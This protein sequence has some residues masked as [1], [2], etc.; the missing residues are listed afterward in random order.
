MSRNLTAVC[1]LLAGVLLAAGPSDATSIVG[2]ADNIAYIPV[3][4]MGYT[5]KGVTVGIIDSGFPRSTHRT[6]YYSDDNHDSRV[7]RMSLY[8]GHNYVTG[9]ATG[10][11]NGVVGRGKGGGDGAVASTSEEVNRSPMRRWAI[12][13]AP[14]DG[15]GPFFI[16][17]E[18][19][20][21]PR[22]SRR[23]PARPSVRPRI[24]FCKTVPDP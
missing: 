20:G 5:G 19:G 10:T 6:F 7:V 12:S 15:P 2:S 13:A 23:G 3:H 9:H 8:N 17:L 14:G 18:V 21:V 11:T 1:T 24:E 22:A 16:G 4:H